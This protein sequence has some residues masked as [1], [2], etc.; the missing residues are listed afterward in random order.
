MAASDPL[1]PDGND[2]GA[3]PG[4]RDQE[5][6]WKAARADNTGAAEAPVTARRRTADLRRDG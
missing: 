5:R 6:A 4:P 3:S 2:G 1:N